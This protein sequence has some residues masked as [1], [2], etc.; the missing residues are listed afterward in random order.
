MALP[1]PQL[2]LEN[3]QMKKILLSAVLAGAGVVASNAQ[4]DEALAAQSGC[5]ACHQ[6]ETKVV[7]PSYKDIAA[8]YK[9]QEGA[10]EMLTQSAINGG[11]NKWGPIPM[12]AKGGRMD[13]SDEDIGKI[14]AWI[15]T[16]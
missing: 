3:R 9:G 4:A 8:K 11:V 10:Q 15:L 7:G 12:P 13:V 5:L 16:L 6:L 2:Q 1:P 14:V